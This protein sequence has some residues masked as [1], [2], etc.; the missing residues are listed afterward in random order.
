[1]NLDL[2][3]AQVMSSSVLVTTYN[4]ERFIKQQL[5]S[6]R[7]QTKPANQVLI[8]DDGSTDNTANVVRTFIDQHGLSN[9]RFEINPQNL[10]AAANTLEHLS[11]LTGDLVFLADQD[12]V[13][14]PR[15]IE[16]M[17]RHM[18]SDPD[19][20]L[21]VSRTSTVNEHGEPDVRGELTKRANSG[22]RIYRGSFTEAEQL[23]FD[24]FLG[25]TT[26]P[27]HAMCFRGSV[28]QKISQAGELPNLS[29]SLGPDWYL[30]MWATALGTSVLIPD[31]LVYR[32][33]HDANISL[34]GMRKTTALSADKSKRLDMLDEAEQAHRA[35]LSNPKLA[36]SLSAYQEAITLRTAN[37]IARRADFTRNPSIRRAAALLSNFDLYVKSAGTRRHAARMWLSD[38]MYAYNINWTI[39]KRA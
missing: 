36:P 7:T 16:I 15:K 37:F 3:D 26:V 8:F 35:I 18:A 33:V 39:K 20:T 10:G 31:V 24:D 12:D 23:T 34:G 6:I 21:L 13:W 27:L 30:G 17:S 32:R 29:K 14:D 4:G 22:S 25:Y 28:L 1:M 9:W 5:E 2:H 38:V 11:Q 19:L